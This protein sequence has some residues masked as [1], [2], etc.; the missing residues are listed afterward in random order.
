M[1]DLFQSLADNL[2][3]FLIY[4][5]I[6][7]VEIIAFVKCVFPVRRTARCLRRAVHQL[8]LSPSGSDRPVW[9]DVMF[10]GKDMQGAWRRFLNNAE[11]LDARGLNC[12]VSDYINDDSAIYAT[13]HVQLSEI[14]PGLLTSLGILGTFIGLVRGLGSLDVSDAAKTMESIPTLI[15]GM[16]FAFATSIA[17]V[18]CSLAFNMIHRMATGSATRAI[19]EFQEAFAEIVMQKP[20]DEGVQ[21]ICQ[22]EDR[23]A[24]LRRAVGDIANRVGD[25]VTQAV[26]R[27]FTPIT[28]SMNH[29]ILGQTQTQVEGLSAIVQQFIGQ[30]NHTLNGQFLQLGQTL[31]A[32]NQSQTV[33]YDT[34]ERTMAASESILGS[35]RDL[36]E[37]NRRVM[38]RFEGYIN[39]IDDSQRNA[40]AFL[41]H[42]SQV[43]SGMLTASGEQTDFLAALKAAQQD[44]AD[45][46]KD[47]AA[48][49]A[50]MT[51]AAQKRQ[52]G[53]AE[54]GL[55][56]AK[57]ME[58]SGKLLS[59]SYS[60][61]VENISAGLSRTLGLFDE[62]MDGV[63]SALNQKLE[64]L[65]TVIAAAPADAKAYREETEGCVTAMSKLQTV[66]TD[67]TETV[68]RAKKGSEVA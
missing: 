2:V 3:D 35:M 58:E 50:Q 66:L 64:E 16:T 23:A 46:M 33:S 63:M 5:A 7:M 15:G 27:T 53:A 17:G 32:L 25:G 19:D 44:L 61:F 40:A 11:Q 12:D 48:V 18:A 57:S 41:T 30:L 31:A 59:G 65:K 68:E 9:Q 43:L 13:G 4:A 21:V 67:L 42:G 29:F 45:S 10:L 28:Q 60:T 8:E 36:Q 37:L 51:D 24:F 49:S 55:K 39:V 62:S 20:L 54:M 38:E 26:E 34:L 6:A 47:Y 14:T 22:Q 52:S 56:M 1:A